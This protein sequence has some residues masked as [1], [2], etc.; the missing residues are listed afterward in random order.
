MIAG[1]S[2][3]HNLVAESGF[4]AS[5]QHAKSLISFPETEWPF[6]PKIFPK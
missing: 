1:R 5:R 2:R 4:P 6:P 3:D